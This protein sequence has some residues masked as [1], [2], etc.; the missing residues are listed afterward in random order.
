MY[1]NQCKINRNN[2]KWIKDKKRKKDSNSRIYEINNTDN[3]FESVFTTN[4]PSNSVIHWL[5]KG[6]IISP[7][8]S[9]SP[10]PHSYSSETKRNRTTQQ[11][12]SFHSPSIK[13]LLW[14]FHRIDMRKYT[15]RIVPISSRTEEIFIL[16]SLG[17]RKGKGSFV[18]CFSIQRERE[19]E[20]ERHVPFRKGNLF[21]TFL[22]SVLRDE[23]W[24]NVSRLMDFRPSWRKEAFPVAS[25]RRT[26]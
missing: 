11:K 15:F 19:R 4:F 25:V 5:L 1:P 12:R 23:K 16:S 17:G 24:R 10:F 20:R 26:L 22:A 18:F 7:P 2:L 13:Q 3:N 6:V 8:P 21:E 9:A 14:R